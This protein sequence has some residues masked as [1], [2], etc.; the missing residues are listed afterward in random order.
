MKIAYCNPKNLRQD[1]RILLNDIITVLDDYEKQGYKLT[2]RQ[3]YY[4]LVSSDI[5]FNKT[6][7]YSKLSRILT[8]ARLCG[9]VDWE[10]IEYRIR[11]PNRPSQWD[12]INSLVNDATYQYRKDRHYNQENYIEIWVE[13]DALSGILLPITQKY[14]LNLMVNR[15]YSSITAMFNASQR[16]QKPQRVQKS[17]SL[18]STN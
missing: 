18:Y 9:L 5:L 12:L 8:D 11:I 3:L 6:Q 1:T 2:L 7:N 13:K 17:M 15:G 16:F 14:H 10:I 4:Q